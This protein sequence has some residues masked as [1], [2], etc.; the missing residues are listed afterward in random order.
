METSSPAPQKKGLSPL[1]W[2]GI[3]CG[4]IIVLGLIAFAV[5]AFM[6]GGKIK[7]FAE[8]AAKNPT[9]TTAT[10]MVA[11]SGGEFVMVEEDDVNLRYTVKETKSGKLITIYWDA[12]KQ[13]PET[14][15]GDFSA[16][17]Q[18]EPTPALPAPETEPAPATN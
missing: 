18:S 17:P 7:Q 14:I 10:T 4:S 13:A 6:F 2:I 12:K 15:E 8:D 1:A 3:G 5:F 9:R 11:V 16:I